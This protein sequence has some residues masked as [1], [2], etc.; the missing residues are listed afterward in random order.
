[1]V[2]MFLSSD[3]RRL[4]G[5]QGRLLD[6]QREPRALIGRQ[7]ASQ[8]IGMERSRL[9]SAALD[10]ESPPMSHFHHPCRIEGHEILTRR[11]ERIADDT[12]LANPIITARMR[13]A[14]HPERR[15]V[16]RDQ[17][18]KVGNKRRVQRASEVLLRHASG[19]GQVMRHHDR[20]AIVI[21]GQCLVE[22]GHVRIVQSD[23]VLW[24][25]R[26]PW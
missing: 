16:L 24:G 5:G 21:H 19:M 8:N 17:P 11:A 26:P 25:K 18:L 20:R 23:G 7:G 6:D 1:M 12:S 2:A 10:G 3:R 22:P 9:P 15:R 14:V 4:Y 13:V